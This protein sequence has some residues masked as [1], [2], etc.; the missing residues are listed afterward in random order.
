[1]DSRREGCIGAC[2]AH[3]LFLHFVGAAILLEEI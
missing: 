3:R 1:M 2:G